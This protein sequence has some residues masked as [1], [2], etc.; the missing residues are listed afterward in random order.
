MHAPLQDKN[1][2]LLSLFAQHPQLRGALL[3]DDTLHTLAKQR[4]ARVAVCRTDAA[5]MVSA[6]MWSQADTAQAADA[7]VALY[8]GNAQFREAVATAL[9]QSG[10]Y[11]L[12]SASNGE[13]QLRQA[14][15]TCAGGLNEILSVYGQAHAPRYPKIDSV[16]IAPGTPAFTQS[17]ESWNA[18][19]DT[20]DDAPFFAPSLQLALRLLQLNHRD[21]AARMEPIE[22]GE[23]RAAVAAAKHIEWSRY[24][25]SVIVVPGAGPEDPNMALTPMGRERAML[26]VQ[27]Y[28]AGKA[29]FILLSGG[30]VH[31][32]QTRF[33]E[34]IEMKRMLR[35]EQHI[36]KSAILV[37][38]YAR[39]TTTN[40]RNAV[41]EVYRDGLPTA[42][43]L[44]VVSDPQQ[45]AYMLN[46]LFAARCE[47]ELHYTPFG[48]LTALSKTSLSFL[49]NVSSLE[50]NPLDPLDP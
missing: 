27:A 30:F 36:P 13:E 50:Q 21:E 33:A 23:N 37:D 46:P 4:A 3:V 44:L 41:R 45:T 6:A 12:Y 14:W 22:A 8:A 47:H 34:A 7:L 48:P 28:R 43:P 5:C 24:Q 40:L 18:T 26:A 15:L 32:A 42:K 38:P 9:A 16:S 1:F 10:A 35:D 20:T 11:A 2:Y 17:L 31:P 19:T 25:Y 29:P 39:H 49:P